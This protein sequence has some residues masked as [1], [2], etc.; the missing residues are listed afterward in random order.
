[1]SNNFFSEMG[2]MILESG[3][4][5]LEM[6]MIN[7]SREPVVGFYSVPNHSRSS[8]AG[9]AGFGQA[10]RRMDG[11]TDQPTDPGAK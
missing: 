11:R 4:M 7:V 6:G 10:D 8:K 9:F 3:Q 1:M 5:I 2:Q